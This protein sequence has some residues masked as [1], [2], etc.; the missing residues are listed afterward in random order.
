MDNGL[1]ALAD[2]LGERLIAKGLT[3]ATAESCTGGWVGK[4]LTGVPGSSAWFDCGYITY[5][6][7]AKQD[8]LGVR[9]MT[10][11]AHGAVS[12]PVVRE[13]AEGVIYNSGVDLSLAISGLAGPGGGSSRKPVGTVWF[14]WSRKEVGTIS[15]RMLFY[16]DRDA[17]RQ[18]A[19]RA[20]IQGALKCVE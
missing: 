19:V 13:M 3:M 20:A 7:R 18:Q 15:R 11:E 12:E 1:Y 14:A 9:S 10:L 2:A 16:G 17:V 8:L 4:E 6:N 5:S